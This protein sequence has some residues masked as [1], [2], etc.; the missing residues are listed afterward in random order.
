VS[1]RTDA[2]TQARTQATALLE[3]HP[4]LADAV[5]DLDYCATDDRFRRAIGRLW[6]ARASLPGAA[7]YESKVERLAMA[8]DPTDWD[9]QQF[10]HHL[11]VLLA[12]LAPLNTQRVCVS[13]HRL[14][15]FVDVWGLTGRQANQRERALS[16]RMN[17]R[18]EECRHCR[19]GANV[20]EPFRTVTDV[21]G[22]L[23][24]PVPLCRWH[25]DFTARVN[26]EATPRE[27][28]MHHQGKTI[29]LPAQG[30]TG[31]VPA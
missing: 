1:R 27:T 6:D 2:F 13:A 18:D 11:R 10:D 26:R 25:T 15:V 17:E 16:E 24:E 4:K 29:R 19:T 3:D 22:I 14:R 30:R 12:N 20:Y 8:G 28:D 21:G 31:R 23:A 9:R 7:A 5:K